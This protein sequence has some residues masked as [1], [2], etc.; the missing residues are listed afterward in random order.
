MAIGFCRRQLPTN[1]PPP[2]VSDLAHAGAI[3]LCS[4]EL[5]GLSITLAKGIGIRLYLP[6]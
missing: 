5:T 6:P 4:P 3:S 2:V 1:E